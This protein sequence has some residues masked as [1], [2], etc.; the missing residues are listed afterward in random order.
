MRDSVYSYPEIDFEVRQLER[1]AE[2]GGLLMV[3]PR[4]FDVID[5][6]NPYMEQQLGKIDKETAFAEWHA[7]KDT[8]ESLI[9]EGALSEVVTVEGAAGLVDMVFCANPVFHWLGRDGRKLMVVSNMR[10]E[11]RRQEAA[12]FRDYF[13]R[14]GYHL[15]RVPEEIMVEG[16]GD[17]IPHPGRRLIWMGYGFRTSYSAAAYLSRQ[18]ETPVIP[19]QL[20]S[21]NFYHLDTCFV[22]VDEDHVALCPAAFSE[23]SLLSIRKV[24][25][26]VYEIPEEEAVNTF[27]LNALVLRD[28][29][30]GK[31]AV[32]QHGSEHMKRVLERCNCHV[33]EIGTGEFI[34]SG[35]SV[36]CMKMFLY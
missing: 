12:F 26:H 4:Y 23:D 35:G 33:L 8:F 29:E 17:L 19:L 3:T 32:I 24:F 34:K 20:I 2:P 16:N 5:V 25:R 27:A 14:A 21:E 28:G 11:G 9:V 18:L 6:K 7:L 13:S 10:H 22:P 31:Y 30:G 36:Y 15:I 1:M